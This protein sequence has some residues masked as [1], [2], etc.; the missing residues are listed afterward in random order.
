MFDWHY[1]N[2]ETTFMNSENIKA[3]E[4]HRLTLNLTDK[5]DLRDPKK[6]MALANLSIHCTWKDIKSE[7]KNN[8][9][10]TSAP[11]WNNTFHLPDGSY[12]TSDQRRI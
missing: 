10:K 1:L 4:P 9:F 6:S 3:S 8:K 12:S 2:M 7:Y 11:T 5:F